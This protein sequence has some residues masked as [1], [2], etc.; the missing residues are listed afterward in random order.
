MTERP[1]WIIIS[2]GDSHMPIHEGDRGGRRV[3]SY[4]GFGGGDIYEDRT[5]AEQDAKELA[6]HR[7][8]MRFEVVSL[9]PSAL[10]LAMKTST[11]NALREYAEQQGDQ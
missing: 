3:E 7:P 4:S 10:E 1:A 2:Y 5:E 9:G 11:T 8:D 6:H